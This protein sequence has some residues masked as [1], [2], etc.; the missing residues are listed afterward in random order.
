MPSEQRAEW[1]TFATPQGFCGIAWIEQG[2]TAF[3]LPQ[4]DASAVIAYLRAVSGRARASNK[5]PV[6]LKTLMPRIRAHLK[7]NAQ[8]FSAVPLVGCESPQSA[9][10][11]YCRDSSRCFFKYGMNG[12]PPVPTAVGL[13]RFFWA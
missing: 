3:C 9:P 12:V 6:W 11:K 7:G 1:T 2:I 8:D 4:A 13:A 10:I 5:L